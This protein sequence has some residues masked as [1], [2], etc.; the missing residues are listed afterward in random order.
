MENNITKELLA[1]VGT[2]F[3][4]GSGALSLLPALLRERKIHSAFLIYD[5]NTYAVAGKAVDEL[6]SGAGIAVKDCLFND[7]HLE[8]NE[9]AV[10]EAIMKLDACVDA[11]IGVGSGVINDISKIVANVS[12][13]PYVIVATAP[14]M[15]GYASATSSMCL[16]GLKVSIPSKCPDVI[17]G[18]T[19]I[20][21]D[22]PTK[23]MLAG[24]GDM[25]AKYIAICDWR[26]SSIING[27]NFNEDIAKKVRESLRKCVSNADALLCREEEATEAVFEGLALCGVAMKLAG[28]SRPASGAEHYISHIWDM[29]GEEFGTHTDLHGIQCAVGTYISASVYEMLTRI[30]PNREKALAYTEGFSYA[31]WATALKELL[32]H[33]ADAMI[34]L[35]KKEGKYDKA[36]HAQR[37][38]CIIERWDDILAVIYEEI[39]PISELNELYERVGLP[40]T[41]KEIGLDDKLLQ[42]SFKA[43]KDIRDKYVLSRLCHDLGVAEELLVKLV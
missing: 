1:K 25:L 8:P 20:L 42:M 38:E 9:K 2:T 19:E 21:R 27:E 37:L 7:S 4:S 40:R 13:K 15:D 3:I 26:I 31:E 22:A 43:S 11:V 14:S 30:K 23:M 12:R 35:E 36:R 33:G 39:P 6:L 18:D 10:G 16:S 17:L 5:K 28:C 41:M 32:G 29:R 34:A 24:L